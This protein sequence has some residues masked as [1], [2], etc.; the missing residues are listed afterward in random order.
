MIGQGLTTVFFKEVIDNLRDRRTLLTSIVF[1]PLFGPV[2]FA[3]MMVMVLQKSIAEVDEA[4]TLPVL[5]AENAPNLIAFL[6]ENNAVI[7]TAPGDP[8]IAVKDAEVAVVLVIP[9]SFGDDFRAGVPATLRLVIDASNSNHRKDVRR[10][11]ALLNAYDNEIGL[12]RL[13]ARGVSPQVINPLVIEDVDVSTPTSR[14][15]LILGMVPYFIIFS[16]LL[17]AFYVAIDST[18]GERER[19]TLEPLLTLPIPRSKL[20][21]GKLAACAV[22]STL[23]LI[24]ALVA[25]SISIRFV[26]LEKIGMVANFDI[27]VML[28]VFLV[29]LPFVVLAVSLLTLVASFTK[30]YKEAQTWLSF[31]L[32]PPLIPVIVSAVQPINPSL[33]TMLVP[34]LSQ[35][36]LITEFMKGE[37][38]APELVVVS[39]LSTLAV[40]GA[41]AWAA[42]HFYRRESLL[43]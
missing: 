17:G 43:G 32:F 34:S 6:E 41:L 26:P 25:F 13:V 36:L 33:V 15:V 18:A 3:G 7:E 37:A 38:V 29:S 35:H 12:L 27:G 21:L 9:E 11:R 31:V 30:S 14:S 8:E 22:F 4:L 42:A 16:M 1:G 20:M 39:V 24:V 2:L 5:G 10:T 40:G 28:P 19:G 23:S